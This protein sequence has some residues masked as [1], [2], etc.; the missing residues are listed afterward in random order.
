MEIRS[1]MVK[2]HLAQWIECAC[3]IHRS[4]Q[5]AMVRRPKPSI[6]A[7]SL[8]DWDGESSSV[9]IEHIDLF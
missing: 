8:L 6:A 3:I 7:I 2:V 5:K 1:D 4:S 9:N